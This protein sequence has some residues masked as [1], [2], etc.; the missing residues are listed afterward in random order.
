M[1]IF[2]PYQ[3]LFMLPKKTN[4]QKHGAYDYLCAAKTF[5]IWIFWCLFLCPVLVEG[6]VAVDFNFLHNLS[7]YKLISTL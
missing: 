6:R 7:I 4:I 2:S 1:V 3:V 5:Y